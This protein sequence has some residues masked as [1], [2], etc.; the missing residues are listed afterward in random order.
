MVVQ[1][2][3]N[4]EKSGNKILVR[5]NLEKS[6]NFT[7]RAKN[8]NG[9][10][11]FHPEIRLGANFGKLSGQNDKRYRRCV[12]SMQNTLLYMHNISLAIIESNWLNTFR[13]F[14]IG[15]CKICSDSQGGLPEFISLWK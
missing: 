10:N 3:E 12:L 2:L 9:N 13:Y 6:G 11:V 1:S 14:S 5:E 4:L 8:F 15:H 7:K